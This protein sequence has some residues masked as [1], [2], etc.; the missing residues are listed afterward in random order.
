MKILIADDEESIVSIL[1]NFLSMKG[2]KDVDVF[3]NGTEAMDAMKSGGYDVAFLDEKM[4]GE[5]GTEIAGY[6]K[7]N[8]LKT[9]AVIMTGRAE[10]GE[11]EYLV[12]PFHLQAVEE[13]IEKCR[14]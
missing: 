11:G 1:K 9:K 5:S 12:K 10:T 3:F 8:G 6:I 4:P 13:I 14:K 2:Y 7:K